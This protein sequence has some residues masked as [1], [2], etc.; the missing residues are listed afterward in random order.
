MELIK[1]KIQKSLDDNYMIPEDVVIGFLF[2]VMPIMLICLVII[3]QSGDFIV[4]LRVI[5]NLIFQIYSQLNYYVFY[6][7]R[8]LLNQRFQTYPKQIILKQNKKL[9]IKNSCQ[10]TQQNN[11]YIF[12]L[13]NNWKL[14]TIKADII[15]QAAII[16][17][18]GIIMLHHN[19]PI[20]PINLLRIIKGELL[21]DLFAQT[22]VQREIILRLLDRNKNYNLKQRVQLILDF[23]KQINEDSNLIFIIFDSKFREYVLENMM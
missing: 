23:A 5:L 2:M 13:E 1:N 15:Q 8:K 17:N 20:Q 7:V 18:P 14:S 19:I 16:D 3:L 10:I 22:I 11:T 9:I 6:I 12:E 4:S 21:V